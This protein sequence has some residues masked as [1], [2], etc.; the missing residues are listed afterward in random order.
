MIT[1]LQQPV[2]H[3]AALFCITGLTRLLLPTIVPPREDLPGGPQALVGGGCQLPG[4]PALPAT[5]PQPFDRN[6]AVLFRLS[7]T[8]ESVLCRYVCVYR[9]SVR[10]VY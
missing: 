1:G 4:V 5:D 8:A 2:S 7:G 6:S 10:E 9:F 3:F